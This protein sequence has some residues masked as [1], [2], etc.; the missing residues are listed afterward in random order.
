MPPADPALVAE[1]RKLVDRFECNRCHSVPDVPEPPM[2]K[3]CVGC[4][5][6]IQ[7]GDFEAPPDVLAEWQRNIVDLRVAPALAGVRSR[8]KRKWVRDYLLT[9]TDLRPKLSATM[10]RLRMTSAEADAI[11]AFLVP[12]EPAAPPPKGDVARGRALIERNRCGY[13]HTFSGVPPISSRERPDS[14]DPRSVNTATGQELAPDLRYARDR[15]QLAGLFRWLKDPGALVAGTPMP[16]YELT[17]EEITH[18]AA[19]ILRAPLKAV[20]PGVIPD[21]LPVLKRAVRFREVEKRVFRRICWHCHADEDF[22][23]GDGGPGNTG[24]FGFPP[25]GVDL[26]SYMAIASGRLDDEGSRESLFAKGPDG[27]PRLVAVMLARY[28]EVAGTTRS[29][30]RGMPLGLPPLPLE[31]I[32]L[33]DT[34][35]QQGRPR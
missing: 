5:R 26:S 9:P 2:R 30:L 10:P 8:V 35:I 3:R 33:V 25:R 1:G 13:C 6:A 11:A 14:L 28:A 23:L 16:K 21:R 15:L 24:G 34:W 27:V 20:P 31:D 19:Y 7:D 17:G 32:Q 4:H 22:A 29:G 18:V 12:L